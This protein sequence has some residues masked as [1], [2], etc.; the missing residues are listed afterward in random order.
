[1]DT[2]RFMTI[3]ERSST[4]MVLIIALY[5]VIIFLAAKVESDPI[6]AKL[7]MNRIG[8]YQF[9]FVAQS[10]PATMCVLHKRQIKALAMILGDV[11]SLIVLPALS[12]AFF[13]QKYYMSDVPE[14]QPPNLFIH[15]VLLSLLVNAVIT[16]ASNLVIPEA[17]A[18]SFTIKADKEPLTFDQMEQIMSGTIECMY[19]PLGKSMYILWYC[20]AIFGEK[21]FGETYNGCNY[22]TY[23]EH[24]EWQIDNSMPKPP[25]C[26]PEPPGPCG[27]FTQFGSTQLG[28]AV[29]EF[30][31]ATL[32]LWSWK[33][34]P[35]SQ[36]AHADKS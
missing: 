35:N 15:P 19:N 21:W 33:P 23:K 24:N 22:E 3:A 7:M 25:G 36:E 6:E 31:T 30:P 5:F 34:D 17:L 9:G 29:C 1:L 12:I 8:F 18:N 16:L 14:G 2:H 10:L 4:G 11:A 32:L 27:S 20:F 13:E 26:D 28:M